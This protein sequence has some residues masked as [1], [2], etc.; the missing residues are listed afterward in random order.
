M[1]YFPST[2]IQYPKVDESMAQKYQLSTERERVP[3]DAPSLFY[4]S[5]RLLT[6]S[7]TFD[8]VRLESDLGYFYSTISCQSFDNVYS[9]RETGCY[10]R[11]GSGSAEHFGTRNV[12]NLN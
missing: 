11:T 5:E 1:S 10:C 7:V 9:G 2:F 3:Q 4:M 12:V 6:A 8:N